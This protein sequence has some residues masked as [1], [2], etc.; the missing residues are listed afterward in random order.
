MNT[1]AHALVNLLLVSRRNRPEAVLPLTIGSLLPDAAMIGFY[2]YLR[3]TGVPEAAIWQR[4]YHNPGWQA[5]FDVFN[6]L[7][8]IAAAGIAARLAGWRWG[9]W[10]FLGMGL[11]A[12]FDL[13]LHHTD[14]HRHFWPL[15]DWRFHSPVSYWDANHFGRQFS[16]LETAVCGF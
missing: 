11:H 2:G 15:S 16:L 1:P 6:S 8:L 14:A 5:F 4:H 13:P 10:L 7:P 9:V 3:L 12:L